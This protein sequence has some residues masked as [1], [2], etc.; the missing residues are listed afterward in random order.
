MLL[1]FQP[2]QQLP[3]SGVGTM[4][5]NDS[6]LRKRVN[7]VRNRVRKEIH[8]R[9]EISPPKPAPSSSRVSPAKKVREDKPSGGD[10]VRCP[11]R[12]SKGAAGSRELPR[13]PGREVCATYRR[14][15]KCDVSCTM[16]HEPV[17][18]TCGFRWCSVKSARSTT[19]HRTRCPQSPNE[20]MRPSALLN[21]IAQRV[22]NSNLDS[23]LVL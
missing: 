20:P 15:G 12:R 5:L 22:I 3:V 19:L 6:P 10:P 21:Q 17:C 7:D 16:P 18:A 2:L 8:L 23:I 4:V 13:N 1:L 9:G 14:T 11:A